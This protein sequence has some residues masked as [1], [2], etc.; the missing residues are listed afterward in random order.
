MKKGLAI[1]IRGW[2]FEFTKE[3]GLET[4]SEEEEERKFREFSFIFLSKA[5]ES[6][7]RRV[8]FPFL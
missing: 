8:E 1:F 2:H 5:L 3:R 6:C 7:N 4:E